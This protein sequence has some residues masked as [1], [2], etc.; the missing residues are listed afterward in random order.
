MQIRNCWKRIFHSLII[1]PGG[2]SVTKRELHGL[3]PI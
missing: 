3:N 1:R 2:F